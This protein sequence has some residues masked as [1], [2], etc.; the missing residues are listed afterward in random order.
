M[1]EESIDCEKLQSQG[2]GT[3]EAE[4]EK[5]KGLRRVRRGLLSPAEA[6]R[7]RAGELKKGV[8]SLLFPGRFKRK[9]ISFKTAGRANGNRVKVQEKMREMK[10]KEMEKEKRMKEMGKE[11]LKQKVTEETKVQAEHFSNEFVSASELFVFGG[12]KKENEKEGEGGE[13][14]D[15][16][17]GGPGGQVPLH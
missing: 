3:K 17:E 8:M 14:S 13:G 12:E 10:R 7:V 11:K 1:Q 15:E 6:V 5:M 9:H 4:K 16:G 2:T